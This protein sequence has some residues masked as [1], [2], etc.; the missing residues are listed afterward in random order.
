MIRTQIFRNRLPSD[1]SIE[2][3]TQC[4]PIHDSGMNSESDN[5]PSALIH[6]D[7]HPVSTQCHRFT[8]EQIETVQTIFRVAYEAEP[9]RPVTIGRWMVMR[10]ENSADDILINTYTERQ[11]DL[12]GNARTSPARITLF[13]ID[14]R[15]NQIQVWT[16]GSRFPSALRRK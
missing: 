12:F 15:T 6:N 3:P 5:P 8:S 10:R 2:H 13:H 11:G 1:C 4:A 9:R 16:F 14:N 7:Q